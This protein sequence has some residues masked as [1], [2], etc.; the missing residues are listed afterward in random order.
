MAGQPP[1]KVSIQLTNA[2]YT[3]QKIN[4]FPSAE[5][6]VKSGQSSHSPHRQSDEKPALPAPQTC[7]YVPNLPRSDDTRSI[8]DPALLQR[9]A[10]TLG[11][12]RRQN[13]PVSLTGT[14]RSR[15]AV[16]SCGSELR[17]RT[18]GK[19][20]KSQEKFLRILL[21]LKS[22]NNRLLLAASADGTSDSFRCVCRNESADV[23]TREQV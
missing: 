6:G 8:K 16:H 11:D 22:P 20:R 10:R 3:C 9:V 15:F 23:A 17:R 4:E 7:L 1:G 13:V 18:A 12:Q 5:I 19:E 14:T 2:W 21:I